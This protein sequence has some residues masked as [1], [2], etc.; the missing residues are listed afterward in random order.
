MKVRISNGMF[1]ALMINMVY[2]KAIGV[3]QGSMAREIGNDIW[4]S[5]LISVVVGLFIIVFTV[6]IV[7]RLPDSDIIHQSEV[8]AG[9][10]FGRIIS[11]LV[12]I[13]FLASY[14]TI[15]ATFVYHIK[16][17]FLP[18]APILLVVSVAFLLGVYAIHFGIEVIARMALIGV[19]SILALNILIMI[20]S[21]PKFDIRELMPVFESGVTKTIWASRH[22][23]ADWMMSIMMAAIILPIVKKQ[24]VWKN[25]GVAGI[26]YGGLFVVIWPILEI[27]VLSA[28]VTGQYI[29]S[30]MQMARSAEIGHFIHRYEMMMVALFA[31]SVL[32]QIMMT[33]LCA[34]VSI[35]RLFGLKDYR[36]VIIPVCSVLTA[37]GYW[38]VFDHERAMM[39][40]E[41]Y[42]VIIAHVIGI[43][44][45]GIVFVLGLIFKKK[46]VVAR[47]KANPSE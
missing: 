47:E 4:I 23:N 38:V 46:L 35:Q 40:I 24:E 36:P 19:F 13:F 44:V 27:G 21:L 17:Y 42:W 22:H 7:R 10:W 18:D 26:A 15:M 16:D 34:S 25:S 1:M 31:L 29:V 2:A 43:G 37:Y 30:C 8:L 20:G 39:F 33:F 6:S 5:T 11:L 14:G 9:K 41:T 28:E 32:T 45:L 3:T 12:F